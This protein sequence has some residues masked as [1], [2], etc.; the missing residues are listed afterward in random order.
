MFNNKQVFLD[1]NPT[2]NIEEIEELKQEL[3]EYLK[4]LNSRGYCSIFK[5]YRLYFFATFL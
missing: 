2:S 4:D 1:E 3:N 5:G